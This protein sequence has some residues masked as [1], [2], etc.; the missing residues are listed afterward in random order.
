MCSINTSPIW[1]LPAQARNTLNPQSSCL[2]HACFCHHWKW[3]VV[4]KNRPLILPSCF[5]NA[6]TTYHTSVLG[7]THTHP[8]LGRHSIFLLQYTEQCVLPRWQ[9]GAGSIREEERSN[10]SCRITSSAE[11]SSGRGPQEHCPPPAAQV[12]AR[13]WN[14]F[15]SSWPPF[16]EGDCSHYCKKKTTIFFLNKQL[17]DILWI[18]KR[19]LDVE[20]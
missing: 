16:G 20:G 8:S 6:S 13:L 5:K 1:E 9:K 17:P 7:L 10:A 18:C 4:I 3:P 12:W 15:L 19:L 2:I 11:P 14:Q